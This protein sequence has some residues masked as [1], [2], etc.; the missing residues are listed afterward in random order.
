MAEPLRA[1]E[2]QDGRQLAFAVCGDPDGFPL[3]ML[4]GTPGCRLQRWPVE[5]VY[6]EQG[7]CWVTYDRAGYGQSSRRPGRSVADDVDDVVAIADELG[8]NEFAVGGGSGGGPH[9]LACAAF[10]PDRVVRALCVV[11]VAPYGREGLEH[12]DWL[13]GMDPENVKEFGWALAGEEV[14]IPELE[15]LQAKM[16]ARVA[17]DPSRA[18][19]E[20]ELSESDRKALQR[21]ELRQII[22]E[23]TFEW[24]AHG[25]GGWADD[26][27]A[28]TRA[29]GFDPADITVPVLV[30]YGA[31][32]VLVPPA[33]G[34]WLAAH[35]PG[36]TVY[37]DDEEGHLGADPVAAIAEHVRWLRDGEPPG[38]AA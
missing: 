25:V 34:E 3:L 14:L 37:V 15:S 18:L 30:K 7:V 20:Y 32:D 31:T 27:L 12:D 9:A 4:H 16:E 26:A 11:G 17:D 2:T 10:Q 22:R 8:W 23:S 6:F 21:T 5:E 35:I 28:F 1:L 36:C 19:E 33:H 38:K 29:W 13:A 24:C